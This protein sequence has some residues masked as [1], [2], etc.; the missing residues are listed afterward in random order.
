[1]FLWYTYKDGKLKILSVSKI[2]RYVN[3]FIEYVN[4]NIAKH[5]LVTKIGCGLSR[6]NEK[7]IA[8]LFSKLINNTNVSL[9]KGFINVIL[10]L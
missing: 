10:K 4:N 5:F 7:Y 1:M 8:P 6:Y 2:K 9:P 3:E